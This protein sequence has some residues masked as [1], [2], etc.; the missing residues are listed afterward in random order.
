M[1]EDILL[2]LQSAEFLLRKL[3]INHKEAHAFIDSMDRARESLL[4]CIEQVN[5][6]DITQ[7]GR[8]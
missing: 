2:T 3:T 1:S 7:K 6:G 8:P 4:D 5:R